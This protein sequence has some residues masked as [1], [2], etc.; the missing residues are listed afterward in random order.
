MPGPTRYRSR[1]EMTGLVLSTSGD[2]AEFLNCQSQ[3]SY[4]FEDLQGS[5]AV[6][7]SQ[8]VTFFTKSSSSFTHAN[9]G[10]AISESSRS[11]S[12]PVPGLTLELC[13]CKGP[14]SGAIACHRRVTK[15]HRMLDVLLY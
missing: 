11:T 1:A 10:A 12:L 8:A 5:P 7:A 6:N 3:G 15:I 14:D 9:C 2:W 4:L 13:N